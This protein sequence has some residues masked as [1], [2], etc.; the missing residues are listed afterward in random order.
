MKS[1]LLA[2]ATLTLTILQLSCAS[3]R[4]R[5]VLLPD[6]DGKVGQIEVSTTRGSQ[7]IEQAYQCIETLDSDDEPCTPAPMD[8]KEIMR[9]Y[10]ETLAMQ[11]SPRVRLWTATLYCKNG[12]VELVERSQEALSKI[13]EDFRNNSPLEVYVIGHTDR[14]GPERYNLNL[15]HNRSAWIRDNLIANGIKSKII[16]VVFYGDT[17][18]KVFTED[19]VPE[20]LNRRVEL[21]A[22]F[23][24]R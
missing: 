24:K 14:V 23:S 20:P 12:S 3:N 10:G 18:P 17:K 1:R 5:V 11:P 4:S 15:S 9:R 6:P 7:R 8:Q 21:V 16:L 2:Y 22:K 13:I 19:E